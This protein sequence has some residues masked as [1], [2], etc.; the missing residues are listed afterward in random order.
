[1]ALGLGRDAPR[2]AASLERAERGTILVAMTE[3][4]DES[5]PIEQDEDTRR[6]AAAAVAAAAIGWWAAVT[7][8][9]YGVIFFEQRLALWAIATTVFFALGLVRGVRLWLRPSVLS[10]LLP[11]LWLVL[12]WLL[13]VGGTTPASQALFWFGVLV[14]V[15]GMPALAGFMVRLLIPGA[16]RMQVRDL[17]AAIG[18][19]VAIMLASYGLGIYNARILTCADFTISGNYAPAGC[20][21]GDIPAKR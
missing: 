20:T 13:P 6:V 10:L 3:S 12:S 15:I 8:G 21:P 19:V 17:M 16:N 11:S 18:V 14:T 2:R 4:H 7:L 5:P 1:M 9:A